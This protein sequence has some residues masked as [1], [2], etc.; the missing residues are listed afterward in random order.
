MRRKNKK[1]KNKFIELISKHK[2]LLITLGII[3]LSFFYAFKLPISLATYVNSS[4]YSLDISESPHEIAPESEVLFEFKAITAFNELKLKMEYKAAAD[5]AISIYDFSGKIISE[6]IIASSEIPESPAYSGAWEVTIYG[7]A[8]KMSMGNY[9]VI[10]HNLS[11]TNPISV[12]CVENTEKSLSMTTIVKTNIGMYISSIC[13]VIILIYT[14]ILIN[15][16]KKINVYSFFLASSICFSLIYLIIFLPWD[17]PDARAHYPAI[18]RQ[19]NML[20]GMPESEEWMIRTD[21]RDLMNNMIYLS[22]VNIGAYERAFSLAVQ[23][24]K[25]DDLVTNGTDQNKMK[26]YSIFCYLPITIGVTIGRLLGLNGV[27]CL[28]IGRILMIAFYICGCLRAVKITPVGKSAFALISLLPIPLMYSSAISYDG[29]LY[30]ISL[31]FLANTFSY[32]YEQ[33]KVTFIELTIWSFMLGA[34]KGGGNLLLLS[35]LFMNVDKKSAPKRIIVAFSGIISI[36]I[37]NAILPDVPFFQLGGSDPLR[38]SASYAFIHPI[39]FLIMMFNTYRKFLFDF[40]LFRGGVQ[41]GA[42]LKECNPK[43]YIVLLNTIIIYLS[44]KESDK[45]KL[46]KHSYTNLLVC[47]LLFYMLTPI[48]L[49]SYTSIHSAVIIGMQGRYFLVTFPLEIILITKTKLLAKAKST[50]HRFNILPE[51]LLLLFAAVSIIIIYYE[52]NSYLR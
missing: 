22:N 9:T 45:I 30:V 26:F 5:F 14:L 1:M 34:V 49:L 47:I 13:G 50:I 2:T 3:I 35:L 40:W 4:H 52:L 6:K 10:I 44:A 41:M 18:Y 21:D 27:I 19:S 24:V 36:I 51:R 39:K 42:K 43:L 12:Y 29:V 7:P 23:P 8:E 16:Y 11:D 15:I 17:V 32:T 38:Y 37:F 31:L 48:M 25:F 46:K 20:M 28:Y 33:K